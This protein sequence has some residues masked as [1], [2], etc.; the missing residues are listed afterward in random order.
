MDNAK[1]YFFSSAAQAFA[2]VFGLAAVF[3]GRWH[4]IGRTY[5]VEQ[6]RFFVRMAQPPEHV[7]R[8]LDMFD[9]STH[10]DAFLRECRSVRL[11]DLAE[12]DV[13][14]KRQLARA[15][16]LMRR[17]RRKGDELTWLLRLSMVFSGVVVVVSAV[18]IL[19][20]SANED[21]PH[22][23]FCI[24][25]ACVCGAF[26]LLFVLL[27]ACKTYRPRREPFWE[28]TKAILADACPVGRLRYQS[29]RSAARRQS[30]RH[31]KRRSSP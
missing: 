5:L 3:A 21:S 4:A 18:G 25:I 26:S 19:L 29:T 17:F 20:L 9:K 11:E 22:V 13:E 30:R 2:A 28:V 16:W 8:R 10:W 12:N 24:V 31:Q 27:M 14:L 6:A 15:V 23:V 7:R 1:L